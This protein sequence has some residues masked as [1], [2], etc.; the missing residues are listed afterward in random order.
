MLCVHKIRVRHPDAIHHK[1]AKKHG[2]VETM[3]ETFIFPRLA[4]EDVQ[5]EVLLSRKRTRKVFQSFIP[6]RKEGGEYPHN[7]LL[8]RCV[9]RSVLIKGNQGKSK[10]KKGV[11]GTRLLFTEGFKQ[12]IYLSFS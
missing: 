5:A 1:V 12:T 6:S 4:K 3:I 2:F 8:N 7:L 10:S 9:P 11:N